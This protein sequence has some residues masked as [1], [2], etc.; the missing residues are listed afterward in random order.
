MPRERTFIMIKPD[1]VQRGLVAKVIARFEQKGFKLVAMKFKT[2]SKQLLEEHYADLKS[3][4]FFP[5][6]LEYMTSGPVVPMVWEGDGV[7]KAGRVLLGATKPS[8]SAPGSIR[9]DYCIDVG[10]NICHGS[11]AVESATKEIALW[12]TPE[13]VVD[14]KSHSESM[15]YE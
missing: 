1:G 10:R 15:L 5:G 12:F 7:V 8:E 13:E 14:W 9:G 3:K 6:L 4:P 11:D 2:P